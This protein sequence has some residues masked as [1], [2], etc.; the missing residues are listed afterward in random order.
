MENQHQNRRMSMKLTPSPFAKSKRPTSVKDSELIARQR[1]S[2]QHISNKKSTVVSNEVLL[3]SYIKKL[4][5]VLDEKTNLEAKIKEQN[6]ELENIKKN[7][8]KFIKN[9]TCDKCNLHMME[10][11]DI[12]VKFRNM[13][14]KLEKEISINNIDQISKNK[15]S[16]TKKNHAKYLNVNS[17]FKDL[18]FMR[19]TQ[20]EFEA[21]FKNNKSKDYKDLGS[22]KI[23]NENFEV[24]ENT[25]NGLGIV[26]IL[27]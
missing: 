7:P 2:T 9:F 13:R 21:S 22:L 26:L 25:K 27:I 10:I 15:S 24:L 14:N 8:K 17:K 1:E 20:L 16:A 3:D 12:L 5:L 19:I 23:Y 6:E 4:T 18:Y 11:E